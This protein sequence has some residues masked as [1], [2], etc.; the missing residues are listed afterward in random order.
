MT[1]EA[2]EWSDADALYMY[3]FQ[4]ILHRLQTTYIIIFH[5]SDSK[6]NCTRY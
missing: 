5:C 1:T 2:I 3:L 4:F 6:Y